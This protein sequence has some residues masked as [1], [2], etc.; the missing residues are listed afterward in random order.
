M[1]RVPKNS[2]LSVRGSATTPRGRWT[3]HIATILLLCLMAAAP[4]G[5]AKALV[6]GTATA[7]SI[8]LEENS[9][10]DAQ[11]YLM[12]F[13]TASGDESPFQ[14]SFQAEQV[15]ILLERHHYMGD[16]TPID[17]GITTERFVHAGASGAI[18][19][20]LPLAYLMAVSARPDDAGASY[21]LRLAIPFD[22]LVPRDAIGFS[23]ERIAEDDETPVQNLSLVS[24]H[25]YRTYQ[26]P[27]TNLLG[28]LQ[29]HHG[30]LVLQGN[31][32]IHLFDMEFQVQDG[33]GKITTYEAVFGGAR[34]D[35]LPSPLHEYN[36]TQAE[37]RFTN[38]TF[39]LLPA[40]RS[41]QVNLLSAGVQ[42]TG[43]VYLT[44]ARGTIQ[45]GAGIEKALDGSLVKLDANDLRLDVYARSET[46]PE[47][48]LEFEGLIDGAVVDG[49][50]LALLLAEPSTENGSPPATVG[51]SPSSGRTG[52]AGW[53]IGV[54]LLAAV[55][56]AWW[57][58]RNRVDVDTMI[59][60]AKLAMDD[61]KST[62]AK[63]L[64]ARILRRDPHNET[65]TVM[66]AR[67]SLSRNRPHEALEFL[68][69]R[70][71]GPADLHGGV[72]VAYCVA[73]RDSGDVELARSAFE[74]AKR[75][76]PT[77]DGLDEML[78]PPLNEGDSSSYT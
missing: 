77:L 12:G 5:V 35:D 63:R 7:A 76:H 9:P 66:T 73:L 30:P 4:S 41:L 33:S 71:N 47:Y 51:T 67:L 26:R 43:D 55:A 8:Q 53:L 22:A 14:W 70:V 68:E 20:G 17:Q 39:T 60:E 74:K 29:D 64:L 72:S 78:L 18:R 56:A 10:F 24:N 23:T 44:D 32:T 58:R 11:A 25:W 36:N 61:R 13:R 45:D 38:A 28:D 59:Q 69:P 16:V 15:E 27:W 40:G 42:T 34:G 37:L 49:R 19:E 57:L 3:L 62:R 54:T 1:M 75:E 52:L 65:A 48:R 6:E 46:P 50:P 21:G 31:F 2:P